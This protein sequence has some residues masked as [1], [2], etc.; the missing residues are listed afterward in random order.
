MN[1]NLF[2]L[3]SSGKLNTWDYQ[4]SLMLWTTSRI[5]IAPRFNLVKNIGF[6]PD[7]THTLNAD[8]EISK[9]TYI[10]NERMNFPLTPPIFMAPNHKYQEWVEKFATR[11]FTS[12]LFR[13]FVSYLIKLKNI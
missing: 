1:D 8:S 12:K 7:A 6:G 13:T 11:S 3:V 9:L 10:T 5:S 2:D 4:V